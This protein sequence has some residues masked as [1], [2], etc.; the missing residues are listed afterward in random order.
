MNTVMNIDDKNN[1]KFVIDEG[2]IHNEKDWEKRLPS[3]IEWL[4]ERN[5]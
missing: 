2:G 1:M 5:T 4:D 3:I